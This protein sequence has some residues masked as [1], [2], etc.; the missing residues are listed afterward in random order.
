MSIFDWFSGNSSQAS[1]SPNDEQA[2]AGAGRKKGGL[3]LPARLAPEPA[4]RSDS[5]K[6]RHTHRDQLFIGIREAMTRAGVLSG[7]YKFK[8][9]SVDQMGNQFLVM[10]DMATVA[11]DPPPSLAA[12][13]ALI[14]QMAK[15]R[16]DITV[17]SV[18]WRLSEIAAAS[19]FM[20]HPA[21][22]APAAAAVPAAPAP[23]APPAPPATKPSASPYE[24]IHA[25]EVVAFQQALML[26]SVNGPAVMAKGLEVRSGM[27][28]TARF[29]DFEDT[30]MT[31]SAAVAP[32]LSATQYGDLM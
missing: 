21:V 29:T 17:T 12:I 26:A 25:D 5:A 27:R 10:M 14:Q 9:L 18:Y 20:P 4:H 7:S 23:A 24:P 3:T 11:G 6:L 16:F 22:V 2:R 30:E 31:E 13:E 32:A 8:V 19:K 1:S 28:T 15:V